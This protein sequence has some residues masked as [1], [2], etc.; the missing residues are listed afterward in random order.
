VIEGTYY[1]KYS[2]RINLDQTLGDRFNL[3]LRMFGMRSKSDRGFTN[4]DNT[5]TAYYMIWSG[6][7]SFLDLSRRSDG[8]FPLNPAGNSNPLQTAALANNEE[9]VDRFTGGLT[10]TY[11]LLS[12]GT[13]GIRL[14]ANGGADVFAQTN[15]VYTP[16]D[17]QFEC[18]TG[19][20]CTPTDPFPG[21]SVLGKHTST[22][23]NMN[24]NAVHSWTPETTPVS[25]TTSIGVQYEYRDLDISR[26]QA[27]DLFPG[28]QNVNN[29]VNRVPEQ[30]RS[31]SK[32]LG[33]FAQEEFLVGERL[34]LTGSVRADR[35]SN[36]ADPEEWFVYPKASG[37]YRLVVGNTILDEVKFRA[38]WGQSGNQ[39]LYGQKFNNLNPGR[40]GGFQTLTLG[41]TTVAADLHPEQQTEIEGGIDA[42]LFGG[43]ASVEL[44]AYHKRIDDVLLARTLPPSTGF[45]Q[46][47]FNSDGYMTT[48]G[49]E[50]ALTAV[51][52]DMGGFVWTSRT[53][54]SRD[55]TIM[56]SLPV[57]SFNFGGGGFGTSLGAIRIEQG[58]PVTALF[59]RDTVAIAEDPACLKALKVDAGSGQCDVG[60]RYVGQIGNSN[61]DFRMGF[62]NDFRYR[63]LSLTT[64]LDWQKGGDVVNLTGYLLDANRISADFDA[65]CTR[66][67]G[68]GL[69]A[70]GSRERTMGEY[71]LAVYPGRTSRVF[72]EDASFVKLRE[73]ALSWDV[74]GSVYERAIPGVDGLRLTLSGRNLF[75]ITDYTGFDPEVNNFGA[76]AIRGNIDVAPYPPSRSIWLSFD[77]RF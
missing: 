48:D 33:L 42:Y 60:D 69:V 47:L 10:A 17:L 28:Q 74:P 52:L 13:H 73:V 59:G 70:D 30:I 45:N 21:T 36:N 75:T 67:E 11:D 54:F 35:S 1:D 58:Y 14:L 20:S 41:G 50:A 22:L 6:T 34:L 32:D 65:P 3:G 37:S 16:E 43:R 40:L 66:P 19:D 31:R 49:F 72:L 25:A 38:A 64:T 44:T 56:D 26:V 71:R 5:S 77:A 46:A 51:P 15:T 57:P 12:T 29:A 76:Q 18:Q 4:N 62:S 24:V 2:A 63:S 7:P 9:K 27:T 39:P 53:T 55:E 68:C 61:P 8:T 23:A